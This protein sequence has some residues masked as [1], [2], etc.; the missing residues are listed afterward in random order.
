VNF[1]SSTVISYSLYV[2]NLKELR[3]GTF[4]FTRVHLRK[5]ALL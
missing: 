5:S 2:N 3:M 1:T 4:F